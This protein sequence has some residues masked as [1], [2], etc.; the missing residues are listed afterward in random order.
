ME[1]VDSS[2]VAGKHRSQMKV[3]HTST[4]VDT[5][6]EATQKV[7]AELLA[8]CKSQMDRTLEHGNPPFTTDQDSTNA[9]PMILTI[10]SA[11]DNH[12]AAGTAITDLPRTEQYTHSLGAELNPLPFRAGVGANL[13]NHSDVAKLNLPSGRRLKSVALASGDSC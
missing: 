5:P 4:Q 6:R 8:F 7:D 11:K 12:V 1:L 3:L 9:R 2:L 13:L 10:A